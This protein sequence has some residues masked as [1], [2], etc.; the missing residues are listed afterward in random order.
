MADSGDPK[1]RDE[2]GHFLPGNSVSLIYDEDKHPEEGYRLTLLGLT[3]P[4]M[5]DF[6]GVHHLTVDNWIRERPTFAARVFAARE[7]ADSRVVEKLYRLCLGYEHEQE[8]I[9]MTDSG[10]KVFKYTERL[11]PDVKAI[12]KWLHNR[13]RK[14]WGDKLP[15]PDQEDGERPTEIVYRWAKPGE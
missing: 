14:R 13:Q 5:A 8:R 15:M 1:Q 10:P 9:Y 2:R 4:E 11:P 7:E 12:H 3:I 6:W